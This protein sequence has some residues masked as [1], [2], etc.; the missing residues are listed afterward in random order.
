MECHDILVLRCESDQCFRPWTWYFFYF[1]FFENSDT[2][3]LARLKLSDVADPSESVSPVSLTHLCLWSPRAF[4]YQ[5]CLYSTSQKWKITMIPEKKCRELSC[6]MRK[7]VK[8]LRT[9]WPSWCRLSELG[10]LSST[11]W[12][13][14]ACKSYYGLG[15]KQNLRPNI[16]AKIAFEKISRK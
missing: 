5:Q 4:F 6:L 11:T 1:T 8:I 15:L 10:D 3:F 16:F 12:L 13:L 14:Q 9:S 7:P 2:L